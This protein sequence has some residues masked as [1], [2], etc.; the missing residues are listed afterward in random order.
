[1][2][3]RLLWIIARLLTRW[4]SECHFQKSSTSQCIDNCDD[5]FEVIL[6][7]IIQKNKVVIWLYDNI[8]MR[9]EGKIIVR[10]IMVSIE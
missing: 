3:T 1:M 4:I 8:E 6:T 10:F 2:P 9:I 7:S 5:L